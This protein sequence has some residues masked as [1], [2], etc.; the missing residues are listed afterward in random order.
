MKVA[1]DAAKAQGLSSLTADQVTDFERRY[2]TLL[3]AG[4]SANPLVP[5]LAGRRGRTK[6]SPPRNLLDR[7]SIHRSEVLAFL[8]DF[9]VP[10]DNN[11]A[12][13]D[14]RMTKIQQKVSGGFR[15]SQ[16]AT[17]FGQVR[18]YLSTARKNGQRALDVLYQAFVGTPYV[19]PCIPPPTSG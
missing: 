8:H 15:T 9:A 2:T 6:Q 18:G 1:V 7:L 16:G 13:R 19:P 4:L 3:E 11:Q 17:I 10:F 5:P 12:E 14:I